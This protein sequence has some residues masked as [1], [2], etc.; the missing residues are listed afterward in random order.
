MG[1][2]INLLPQI[3]LFLLIDK[4]LLL[5]ELSMKVKN[6]LNFHFILNKYFFIIFIFKDIVKQLCEMFPSL[7]ISII[8]NCVRDN[9]NNFDRSLDTLLNIKEISEHDSLQPI[10]LFLSQQN[11]VQQSFPKTLS[12]A[13]QTKTTSQ[14]VKTSPQQPSKLSDNSK[15]F[16]LFFRN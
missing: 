4:D 5:K 6:L 7:D 9:N 2:R 1:K 12:Q 16:V 11:S 10:P 15:K 3:A 8:H 13:Q 14:Q